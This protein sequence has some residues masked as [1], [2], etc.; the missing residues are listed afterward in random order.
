VG[1][2]QTSREAA[3]SQTNAGIFDN[4]RYS[5][6]GEIRVQVPVIN[7]P[8]RLIFALNPNARTDNPFFYEQKAAIRFSVGRT[9]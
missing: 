7:V 1:D 9:F 6:G 8:F 4:Y 3:L 2:K 5:L